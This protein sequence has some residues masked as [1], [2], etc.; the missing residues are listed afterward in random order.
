MSTPPLH[1]DDNIITPSHQRAPP[2]ATAAAAA[3]T[4]MH[5][6]LLPSQAEEELSRS[7]RRRRS[8]GQSYGS[9]GSAVPVPG[10]DV[11]TAELW[12]RMLAAQQEFHCYNSARVSAALEDDS[13]GA[14]VREFFFPPML[15]PQCGVVD[16]I[17]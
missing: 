8:S 3:A 16:R 10:S 12:Q 11:D 6:P 9:S 2:I 14:V 13:V 4:E 1:D 17:Y 7:R 15:V 5:A